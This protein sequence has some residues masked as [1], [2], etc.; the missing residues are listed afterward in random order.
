[1]LDPA[2]GATLATLWNATGVGWYDNGRR[3]LL[4]QQGRDRTAFVLIDAD[5]NTRVLGS[6]DGVGLNCQARSDVL[7]CAA[8]SGLLRVWPLPV[9]ASRT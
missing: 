1:M 9:I 2:T 5:G 6:V 7:A 4:A 3:V 8:P